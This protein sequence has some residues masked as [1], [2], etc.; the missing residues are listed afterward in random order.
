MAILES[1]THSFFI[2]FF[3]SLAL[4]LTTLTLVSAAWVRFKFSSHMAHTKNHSIYCIQPILWNLLVL[5]IQNNLRVITDITHMEGNRNEIIVHNFVQP[6]GRI[7]GTNSTFSSNITFFATAPSTL[8]IQLR[9]RLICTA[10]SCGSDCSQ[11]TGCLTF[12]QA[13]VPDCD[14]STPCM[15][16]GTCQVRKC[17][18]NIMYFTTIA[19]YYFIEWTLCLYFQLWRCVCVCVC[20]CVCPHRVLSLCRSPHI[21]IFSLIFC[22][23]LKY[24]S[25][26]WSD[27]LLSQP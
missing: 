6:L 13:C 16:G 17:D 5:F 7:S 25:S 2:S 22:G 4:V 26:R 15:N 19:I 3:A 27:W 9:Y 11:T 1:Y 14:Q 20:V 18:G 12:P 23:S 10:G 21:W 24:P 8:T